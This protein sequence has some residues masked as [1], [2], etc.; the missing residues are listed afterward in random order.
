[1]QTK[2]NVR[3]T[4]WSLPRYSPSRGILHPPYLPW[5]FLTTSFLWGL[6]WFCKMKSLKQG[7][8]K[9]KLA[10][11]AVIACLLQCQRLDTLLAH[12]CAEFDCP[13]LPFVL[14]STLK[15]RIDVTITIFLRNSYQK[16][17]TQFYDSANEDEQ[18]Y[19]WKSHILLPQMILWAA[20]DGISVAGIC[21]VLW[22]DACGYRCCPLCANTCLEP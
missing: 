9:S 18:V 10:Y 2:Y 7:V 1:M 3:T 22:L 6:N 16:L 20:G 8:G 11:K 21:F 14:G 15:W 13:Q 12:F 19:C 4:I 17:G 5:L